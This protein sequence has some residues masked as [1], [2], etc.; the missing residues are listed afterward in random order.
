MIFKAIKNDRTSRTVERQIETLVLEGVLTAGD[1]L[2]GERELSQALDVSRPILREAIA[3]LEARQILQK[4]HGGATVVADVTGTVFA[5]SVVQIIREN[6][7]ARA[8]YLEFRREIEGI[9]A[10][11]AATRANEA[12]KKILS[13]IMSE[14]VE[15]HDA[16][17]PPRETEL[18]VK[19]H[20]AISDGAHNIILLHTLRSCYRLL[21]DDVFYN[22]ELIYHRE[23]MREELLTQ[24][25]AIFDAIISGDAV[26]ARAAAEDHIDKLADITRDAEK[27]GARAEISA[28]RLSQKKSKNS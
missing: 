1:R 11:M 22:R 12:D 8:D 10:A 20:N 16:K 3:N 6:D 27:A 5:P 4:R 26:A 25:Q 28:L 9:T 18:D 7:K 13:M 23:G 2:P 24:H 14:M 19:F 15:A 17:D 21:E